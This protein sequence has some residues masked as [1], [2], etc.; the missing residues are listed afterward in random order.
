MNIE[1]MLTAE[2]PDSMVG[3][4]VTSFDTQVSDPDVNV[5]SYGLTKQLNDN[6]AQTPITV[7]GQTLSTIDEKLNFLCEKQQ[8]LGVASKIYDEQVVSYTYT[9]TQGDVDYYKALIFVNYRIHTSVSSVPTITGAD[10]NFDLSFNS[11]YG[12]KVGIVTDLE[13]GK[14]VSM[15]YSGNVGQLYRCTVLGIN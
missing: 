2:M 1:K 14:S 15:S 13:V 7:E 4:V 10:Y 12:A 6:L 5:A 9:I 11:Q 3:K 8:Y